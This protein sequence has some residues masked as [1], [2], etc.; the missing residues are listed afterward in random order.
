MI[1]IYKITNLVNGKIYIGQSVKIKN[2]WGQH[3]RDAKTGNSIAPIHRAIKKYGKEN[4]DFSILEECEKEELDEKERYWI[5]TL[6]STILGNG[7]NLTLGGNNNNSLVNYEKIYQLWDEGYTVKEISDLLKKEDGMGCRSTVLNYLN[8]YKN[9]SVHESRRRS[10]LKSLKD[11]DKRINRRNGKE[12]LY[13]HIYQY[14]LD[15]F[16]IKEWDSVYEIAKYFNINK[17]NIYDAIKGRLVQAAGFQWKDKRV[18]QEENVWGKTNRPLPIMQYDLEDNF[19]SSYVSANEA[20]RAVNGES[21]GILRVCKN[22]EGRKTAYGYKWKYAFD[23]W[24]EI[25]NERKEKETLKDTHIKSRKVKNRPSR[26]ELKKLIREKPFTDIGKLFGITAPAI[27]N[28]CTQ[29]KLPR[30]KKEINSYSDE[31]WELV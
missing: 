4:F 5:K 31:E 29:Y 7:Y 14:D 10:F 24:E 8:D 27:R 21:K 16:F 23:N 13:N 2:R 20:A 9:Y 22:E 1:G 6:N 30:T 15:G 28:W 18:D 11:D 19:I 25:L 17:N 26:D 3:I 12:C